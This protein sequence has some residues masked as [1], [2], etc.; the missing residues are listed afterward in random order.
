MSHHVHTR[1]DGQKDRTTN[2]LISSYVY[3][4]HLC[5]DKYWHGLLFDVVKFWTYKGMGLTLSQVP[6][7][8][9]LPG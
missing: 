2:L 8:W 6:V 3:Y 5:R 1:N 7:K 4:V 9:L